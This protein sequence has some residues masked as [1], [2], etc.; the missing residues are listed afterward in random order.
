MLQSTAIPPKPLQVRDA[1]PLSAHRAFHVTQLDLLGSMLEDN[2]GAR[3]AA[4]PVAD[5]P[6]NVLAHMVP[7][8]DS[9]LWYCSYGMP[10][11]VQFPDSDYLRLQ[12]PYRGAG[13]TWQGNV[14][15]AVSSD[16][17]CISRAEAQIDFGD[18]FEQ[19]VWR[20]P[21]EKLQQKLSLLTGHRCTQRLEFT[22]RIDLGSPSGRL[23]HQMFWSLVSA[24]ENAN[25]PAA[26][27]A[28]RELEQAFITT[29]LA[30][31]DHSGRSLLDKSAGRISPWQVRRAEA[32]IEANWDKALTIEDLV[33]A[34]GASARSLF[35]TFKEARGCSPME[36]ARKLRL[37]HAHR[38]LQNADGGTTVTQ[39]ALA[40]GFGDLG[41]FSKEYQHRFGERPS[42]ALARCKRGSSICKT[43]GH[44]NG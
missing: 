15:N 8:G 36:F 22:S 6:V 3:F 40:C 24:A 32:H 16:R 11:S 39:V 33:E 12:M 2:L 38:M 41:R 43:S 35:R 30:T 28:V 20:L 18:G 25:G 7:L 13:G 42:D 14:F 19:L 29:F 23:L 1:P 21:H 27:F 5:G 44:S 34:S 37:E 31:V 26:R 17:A 4:R 10:V 9:E